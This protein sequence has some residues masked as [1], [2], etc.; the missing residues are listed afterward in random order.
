M[1]V[2]LKIHLIKIHC[3][4]TYMALDDGLISEKGLWQRINIIWVWTCNIQSLYTAGADI[5]LDNELENYNLEIV[6]LNELSW[7]EF[8]VLPEHFY[9][10]FNSELKEDEQY[11]GIGFA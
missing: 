5:K 10:I 4:R 2:G 1:S 3:S 6:A 8:S 9:Q 11:N 7:P